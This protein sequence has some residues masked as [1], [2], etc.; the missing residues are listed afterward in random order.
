MRTPSFITYTATI[1]AVIFT[2]SCSKGPT[3]QNTEVQQLGDIEL[4]L[5][6]PKQVPIGGGTNL[7][8]TQSALPDGHVRVSLDLDPKSPGAYP[9]YNHAEFP[10]EPGVGDEVFIAGRRIYFMPKLVK[11]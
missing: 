9:A 10:L 2:T 6:A 1:L 8:F 3:P 11:P 7:I 5:Q 4:S